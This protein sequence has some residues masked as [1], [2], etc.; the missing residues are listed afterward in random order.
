M[1]AAIHN[2]SQLPL[3]NL[4]MPIG[5]QKNAMAAEGV[6]PTGKIPLVAAVS[7]N[8]HGHPIH[9][10]FSQVASFSKEA[11]IDWASK[12]LCNDCNTVTDGLIGFEGL[13]YSGFPHKIVITG[14]GPES[15]QI[16]DF[17]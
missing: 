12:H 8:E 1:S 3:H 15:V 9:M 13:E 5:V 7:N 16:A 17:N 6:E 14:G 10:H 11:I 2:R 4:M